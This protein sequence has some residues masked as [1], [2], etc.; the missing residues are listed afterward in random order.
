MFSAVTMTMRQIST[1]AQASLC[2]VGL[3][4]RW[5]R[6]AW[7]RIGELLGVWATHQVSPGRAPVPCDGLPRDNAARRA[8]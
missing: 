2:R 6:D 4:C 3:F 1:M 8:L 7:R 5:A